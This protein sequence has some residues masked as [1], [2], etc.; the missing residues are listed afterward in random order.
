MAKSRTRS[1][2]RS[3]HSRRWPWL[4]AI[5]VAAILAVGWTYRAPAQGYADTASAYMARVGCSC[6]F[7]AGRSIDDCA[8]DKLGGMELVTLSE[9]VEAKSVTARFPL[10]ASE[11]ASYRKGYG[12]V[13]QRYED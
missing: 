11:T 12:C 2:A 3:T 13:L 1:A 5:L 9:D 10:L 6:R 8:K 7:V 4:A